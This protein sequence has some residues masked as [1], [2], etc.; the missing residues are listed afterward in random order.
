M[1]EHFTELGEAEERT[2]APVVSEIVSQEEAQ[3]KEILSK[4]EVAEVL[5][6]PAIWKL[7][8][9]LKIDPTAAQQ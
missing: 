2:R 6:D 1:G 4:P 7:I 5:Q 8:D 9:T 3:M